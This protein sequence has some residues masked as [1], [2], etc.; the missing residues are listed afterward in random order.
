MR[1]LAQRELRLASLSFANATHSR[2]PFAY[3]IRQRA[4]R[5]WHGSPV[6]KPSWNGKRARKIRHHK[7]TLRTEL[8]QLT[9]AT[10]LGYF[11]WRFGSRHPDPTHNAY[12]RAFANLIQ[13]T[14]KRYGLDANLLWAIMRTES[15]YR[16]DVVSSVN[17]AGLMQLMPNTARRLA[18]ELN[19]PFFDPN[20]VFIPEI[21]L[22]LA[23][24]YLR[25]VSDKLSGQLP[26]IAAAYNGGPHNV[27]RWLDYRGRHS[28][29]D[30]F[31]EEIPFAQSRRYAKKVS[32]LVALYERVHCSKDDYTFD[33]ALTVD[34][35]PLPNY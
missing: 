1:T 29:M 20:D 12:P 18:E 9:Y 28:A 30:E 8:A 13:D 35:L 3:R 24:K 5:L 15:V 4:L 14:A 26:L 21:N 11:A 16:P 27:A 25:A 22:L 32:R 2:T 34:Y 6:R 10:G 17:A 33:N 7:D 19:L 23:G 31:V